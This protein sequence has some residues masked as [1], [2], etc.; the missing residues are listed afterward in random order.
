[1]APSLKVSIGYRL[2]TASG[3][4]VMENAEDGAF[5]AFDEGAATDDKKFAPFLVANRIPIE[6]G[7]YKLVVE[8]NNRQAQQTYKGETDV[9]VGAGS[10]PSFSGPLV[11][12]SVDRVARPNPFQPFEYFGVQ[13]HPAAR[14]EINHPD[15][16]RL[17]FELHQPPGAT[18]NYQMEYIVTHLLDKEGRRSSTEE[19]PQSEFKDGRLLKSKTIAVNDLDNGD[20]RLIVNLRQAGSNEV[21]ASANMPLRISPE[22]SDLPLYFAADS[23]ALGRPG[24]AAYMRALEAISQKND[25]AAAEYFRQALDQNPANTFAGQDLV[26]LYFSQRKYAPIAD[27]YKRL[28][29]AAFKASPVTLAQIASASARAAT[30]IRRAASLRPAWGSTPATQPC[31]RCRAACDSRYFFFFVAPS[32]VAGA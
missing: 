19:I 27:L 32:G 7:A 3:E 24:V 31:R 29:I 26:Q 1:M 21:I 25:V 8:V 6:P 9:K 15:P 14:H 22:K 23:Q 13:F 28:G 2:T 4:T 30:P 11:T 18:A 12:T 20:Y 17:L 16:L 5:A 10:Q